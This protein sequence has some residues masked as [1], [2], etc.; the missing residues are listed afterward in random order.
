MGSQVKAAGVK[1]TN[2]KADQTSPLGFRSSER[3]EKQREASNSPYS[4]FNSCMV[5]AI[6]Y[7][8]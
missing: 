1:Q 2:T 6:N 4:W 5:N 7:K 8:P 3:A